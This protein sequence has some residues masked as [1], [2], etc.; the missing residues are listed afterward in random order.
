MENI[1]RHI[2]KIVI[3]MERFA[4][5][6]SLHSKGAVIKITSVL[7]LYMKNLSEMI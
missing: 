1:L 6:N 4:D 2:R 7:F 3:D 5:Y